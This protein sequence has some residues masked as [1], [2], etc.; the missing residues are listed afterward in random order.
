MLWKSPKI[1]RI[2]DCESIEFQMSPTKYE[3]QQNNSYFHII[4]YIRVYVCVA[5]SPK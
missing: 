3:Q 2:Y 4:C 1:E 5:L